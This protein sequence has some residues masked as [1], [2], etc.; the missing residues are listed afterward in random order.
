MY[1]FDIEDYLTTNRAGYPFWLNKTIL[2]GYLGIS[3]WGFV[4]GDFADFMS[5]A[6]ETHSAFN[7]ALETYFEKS[8][9]ILNEPSGSTISNLYYNDFWD[10]YENHIKKRSIYFNSYLTSERIFETLTLSITNPP[11]SYD[12]WL[13]DKIQLG[14]VLTGTST[15]STY[16]RP[17]ASGG[18]RPVS[19]VVNYGNYNDVQFK[20]VYYNN[21]KDSLHEIM[22]V[23]K[24][25]MVLIDN[26]DFADFTDLTQ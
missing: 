10:A 20:D 19:L 14:V 9:D 4:A 24:T 15:Y 11:S 25:A 12:A 6:R 8:L 13:T 22:R 23:M 26:D 17:M 16:N 1:F 5:T 18:T 3:G 21:Y 7:K 2:A